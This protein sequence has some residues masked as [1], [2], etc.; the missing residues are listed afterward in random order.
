MSRSTIISIL[1]GL[2]CIVA[3]AQKQFKPWTEWSKSDVEKILNDSAWGQTQ[4]ET[5]TSEMF[6]TPTTQAGGGGSASR[7]QQAATNQAT[8][9]KFRIS[10]RHANPI[11]K[12]VV[13]KGHHNTPKKSARVHS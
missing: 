10:A 9:V 3:T 5:D 8:G 13:G 12:A 11:R 7:D 6:F 1:L 2:S 4:I